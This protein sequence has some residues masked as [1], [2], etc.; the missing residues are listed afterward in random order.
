MVHSPLVELSGVG[1]GSEPILGVM[2]AE[3]GGARLGM[4]EAV[5]G[6]KY[7]GDAPWPGGTWPWELKAASSLSSARNVLVKGLAHW[8]W[9]STTTA[10]DAGEAEL[11]AAG[12]ASVVLVV[13]G[14]VVVKP[15]LRSVRGMPD[16]SLDPNIPSAFARSAMIIFISCNRVQK[17]GFAFDSSVTANKKIELI[18]LCNAIQDRDAC[19]LT[20]CIS[21]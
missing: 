19:E 4:E 7:A 20:L 3:T 18:A 13:V 17:R 5:A 6:F 15:A 12:L 10:A 2:P 21:T 11:R 14:T 9:V 16:V 1:G 8:V